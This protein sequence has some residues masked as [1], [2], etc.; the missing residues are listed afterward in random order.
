M[1]VKRCDLGC[2]HLVCDICGKEMAEFTLRVA[3]DHDRNVRAW[4]VGQECGTAIHDK[5]ASV[6][7]LQLIVTGYV[8]KGI[9]FDGRAE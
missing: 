5:L 8:R 6:K 1:T 7:F 9:D 4:N 2:E 3:L